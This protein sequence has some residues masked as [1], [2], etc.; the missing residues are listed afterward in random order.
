[1]WLDSFTCV[2]WCR[3]EGT[4]S[5]QRIRLLWL[6]HTCGL[7]HSHVWHDSGNMARLVGRGY[8]FGSW[9]ICD[10]CNIAHLYVEHDSFTYVKGLIDT[11]DMTH[12][13]V[14]RNAG[15]MARL[16]GKGYGFGSWTICDMPFMNRLQEYYLEHTLNAKVLNVIWLMCG[17]VCLVHT[18]DMTHPCWYASFIRVTWLIHMDMNYSYVWHALYE[19]TSS[20]LSRTHSWRQGLT[21]YM[22]CLYVWHTSFIHVTWLIHIDMNNSCTWH[23]IHTSSSRVLSRTHLSSQGLICYMTHS[24]TWH[25]SFIHLTRLIHIDMNYSCIWHAIHKSSPILRLCSR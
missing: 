10:V 13:H 3:E 16:V 12:L 22:T 24:Y 15:N 20:V 23:A 9:S 2:T 14:W 11:F 25:A 6:I 19:S 17:V 18:C 5:R 21:P 7:I 1:V 8:G 4:T